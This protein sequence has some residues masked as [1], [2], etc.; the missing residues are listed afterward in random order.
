MTSAMKRI[1]IGLAVC[2]LSAAAMSGQA[3]RTTI[4]KW[5]DGNQ[6]AVAITYDDST[7]NQF[8][9]AVP[10]MNERGL[11]GTFFVITGQIP[12]SKHHPTFVG[13]PIMDILRESATIPTNKDNGLERASMLRYLAVAQGVELPGFRA[14]SAGASD[15]EG[16]L[17]ADRR[18]AG[19]AARKRSDVRGRGEA[20]RPCA[21]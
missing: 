3:P 9:I 20:V 12:G 15:C 8:R 4:T 14:N 19:E 1:P 13:R 16:R 21:L 17:R 5:Q 11:P 18:R 6:A 7:I 2:A 10:L